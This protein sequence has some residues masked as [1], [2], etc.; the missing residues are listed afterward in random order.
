MSSA[1]EKNRR[2]VQLGLASSS[3]RTESGVI[4]VSRQI[5]DLNETG[6]MR[7]DRHVFSPSQT[8]F[9]S[10]WLHLMLYW[11]Y[12]AHNF[13]NWVNFQRSF[14]KTDCLSRI[15]STMMA[16]MQ[17]HGFFHNMEFM[18]WAWDTC[19]LWHWHCFPLTVFFWTLFFFIFLCK[20][21]SYL[22]S[23]LFYNCLFLIFAVVS[24]HHHC[25]VTG[26][27]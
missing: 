20:W 13:N 6:E 7:P 18:R 23:H 26:N 1:R 11:L 16:L 21:I 2:C 17:E 8:H 5:Q 14:A 10:F 3:T 4:W 19:E 22:R 25:V 15:L 24:R 27:V 12:Y 9:F